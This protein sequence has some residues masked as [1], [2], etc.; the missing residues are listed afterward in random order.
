MK[1]TYAIGK[2]KDRLFIRVSAGKTKMVG[3]KRK[4]NTVSMQ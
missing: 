1:M 2:F 3:G 4:S